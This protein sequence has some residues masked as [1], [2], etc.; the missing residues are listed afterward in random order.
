MEAVGSEHDKI[1]SCWEAV[2]YS[3]SLP[4]CPAP[5]ACPALSTRLTVNSDE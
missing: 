3:A 5:N 2:S 1:L 4:Q